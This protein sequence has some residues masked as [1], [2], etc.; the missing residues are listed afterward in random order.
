MTAA[1]I[2]YTNT[3]PD[4]ESYHRLFETTGWNDEYGASADE[5]HTSLQQSWHLISAFDDDRLIGF[6]RTICDGV[7]HALI[8]D[9]IVLPEYKGKGIGS[10][11]LTDLVERCL[12]HNVRDI[13]LFCARGQTG[14]YLKHGFVNRPENAP[15]MQYGKPPA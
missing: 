12:Q 11:I 15:G 6:G 14:F 10:H 13:Q 3:V 1:N 7:M 9:L 4:A 5:L 8:V 2:A